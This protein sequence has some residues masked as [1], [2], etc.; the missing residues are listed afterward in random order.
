MK[1]VASR[2]LINGQLESNVYIETTNGIISTI[3]V[4]SGLPTTI[5]GVV[6]PCFVDIHTHGGGG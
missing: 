3:E 5:S 4:N 6:L 2:A 1:L